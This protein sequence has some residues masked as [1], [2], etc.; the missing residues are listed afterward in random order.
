MNDNHQDPCAVYR[1]LHQKKKLQLFAWKQE[2]GRNWN[3]KPLIIVYE[4]SVNQFCYKVLCVIKCTAL[5][6][7]T[8]QH[9]GCLHHI[10]ERLLVVTFKELPA[11]FTIAK[12][13]LWFLPGHLMFPFPTLLPSLSSFFQLRL[14]QAEKCP[15]C[16]C[17]S[18]VVHIFASH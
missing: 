9:S 14:Y 15:G 4:Y 17:L 7:Q 10:S 16:V 1:K 6:T 3:A 12:Y 13:D 2:Q 5:Y 8:W 18:C 11:E